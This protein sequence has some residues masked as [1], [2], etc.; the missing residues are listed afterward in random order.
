MVVAAGPTTTANNGVYR[1]EADGTM[2][3]TPPP[4]FSG[5]DT[6][7]YQLTDGTNTVNGSITMTMTGTD[8]VWYVRNNDPTADLIAQNNGTSSD[9][10][11]TLLEAQ[12]AS[13]VNHIIYVHVGDGTNSG[14][15]T[16]IT[17][18][19]GQD[20]I[21]NGVALVVNGSTTLIA[22]GTRPSI[23][24]VAGDGVTATNLTGN[25]IRGLNI[26][27]SDDGISMSTSGAS[28]GDIEI[29]ENVIIGTTNFGIRGVAGSSTTTAW[30]IHDN[31]ISG[32]AAA[33][34]L[35][36]TAGTAYIS[37][38]DDNVVPGTSGGGIV[39]TG[40]TTPIIFDATPGG[41]INPVAGGITT[42][43]TSID[44]ISNTGLALL[45]VA[46]TLNFTDL[47][48][49]TD[50]NAALIAD[51][52]AGGFTFTVAP[53]VSTI[54]ANAG[55]AVSLT[56]ITGLDLQLAGM[57]STN[58]A[59]EGVNLTN[60]TGTFSAPTG[61]T[62]TNAAGTD[63]FINGG[64]VNSTYNGTIY[65]NTGTIVSVANSTGGTK[66]FAGAIDDLDGSSD[67]IAGGAANN[68]GGITLS[69]NAGA[70]I[71]FNGG[72]DLSTGATAAFSATGGGTVEVCDESG[73]NGAATGG[74]V[75]KLT[76][77]TG[78]SLNVANTTIGAGDLEFRSISSNGGTA[79]GIILNTTGATGGLS[80]KGT[81]VAASGGTIASKTGTD[82]NMNTGTGV[83]LNNVQ[84][85]V[86]LS[87]MQ[88]N[89]FGNYAIYGDTVSGGFNLDNS[90]ISGVN[91]NN[92]SLDEGS[93]RF[94]N[95]TGAG[96]VTSTNISGGF[97]NNVKVFN[98]TG[99]LDRLVFTGVTIGA[100]STANGND[101]LN[102][103]GDLAAVVKVTVQ[104]SF[105]TSAAGD[106]FQMNHIGTG[107][108][109]L[110]FTGNT[111]TNNHPA[112]ATGGGGVTLGSGSTSNVTMNVSNNTMRDAH[113][114]A[115][116]IVKDVGTGS[117]AVTFDNNNI[118]VAG[119][120]NSG[121]LEGNALKVQ[122]AGQGTMTVS[123]TNNELRQY[124]NEG[125]LMQA[126]AGVAHPGAF[127]LT[128]SGNIIANPG[129]NPA[130]SNVFQGL[131]LNNGVTP[132]D[133]FVT[134]LNLGTNTINGS[135]R[136]GGVDF[137]L[138]A[139]QSTTVRLPQY[140][141]A[142]ND[143]AAVVAYAQARIGGSPSGSA[144]VDP[145][146][147]GFVNT[148]GGAACATP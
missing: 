48:I 148:P 10:F 88:L 131:N 17:L 45:N 72:I 111:L 33:I 82:G 108:G 98:N 47:D 77:T 37:A 41:G 31:T 59:A 109:D 137:R 145:T 147:A 69:N 11:N 140:A 78:T 25:I 123:I 14:Q 3:Y 51:G 73:C 39:V 34:D 42:I 116:L 104:N 125:L 68:G 15:N 92:A 121:S 70:T 18:K 23:G 97:E 60:V 93:M 5:T 113:G 66:I 127:N 2:Y 8:V 129:N 122:Q 94:I 57:T 54:V 62:I 112:I 20:L 144:V 105:F 143:T 49:F 114:H 74:L 106:L 1:I 4:G 110:V 40:V 29:A 38:F 118:G 21:G 103:E 83:Y 55:G 44:R 87:R 22:A 24:N 124:N 102:V 64:T 85:G 146:S 135:G 9:P 136:N 7:P 90:V 12:T 133:T 19:N 35:S 128:V 95:L 71:R 138:R 16:G 99:T 46:G 101:G 53:T 91:G 132:S 28:A 130:F 79:S 119:V 142:A 26:T 61:S 80:V 86:S 30:S 52:G 141:G 84:G 75:N 43:G 36:R 56:D 65:D 139:R 13:G 27:G 117:L 100:N 50:A 115:V 120:A 81:G 67:P 58:S 89:D 126:G 76:T 6:V 63:F 32:T 107:T 134:C 96:T